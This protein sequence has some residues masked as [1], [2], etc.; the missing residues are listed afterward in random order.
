MAVD[1]DAADLVRQSRCGV[2]AESEN[3]QALADAAERMASLNAEELAA[4][5]QRARAYYQQYLALQVGVKRFGEVFRRLG[6]GRKN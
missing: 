1:G 4:M 3:P 6:A 2:V 5:G